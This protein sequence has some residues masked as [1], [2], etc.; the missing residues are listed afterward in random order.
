MVQLMS[1]YTGR[2]P[3]QART[4]V[5][6]NVVVVV[7]E[8][9]LTTAER[10][11]VAADQAGAVALMRRTFQATMKDDSIALIEDVLQRR[12]AAFLGDT[13]PFNDVAVQVFVLE[14]EPVTGLAA[15]ADRETD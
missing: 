15:T 5:N 3:T 14:R 12:V 10:N 2:G 6:T 9:T 4:T 7:F 1:R 11:L 8:E 13:D